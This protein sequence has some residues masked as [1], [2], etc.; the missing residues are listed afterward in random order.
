M[1]K[2][3]EGITKMVNIHVYDVAF[4]NMHWAMDCGAH[5]AMQYP[6]RIGVRSLCAYSKD[7]YRT[8]VSA[9][10]TR[11]GRIVVRGNRLS[12]QTN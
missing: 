1:T 10:R 3:E 5:F 6:D 2:L 7:E 12:I 8:T 4:E 11:S 9:Y